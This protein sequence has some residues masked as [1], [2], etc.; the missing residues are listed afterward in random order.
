MRRKCG[1]RPSPGPFLSPRSAPSLLTV[2]LA[3][4]LWEQVSLE[5]DHNSLF[6]TFIETLAASQAAHVI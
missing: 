4:S 6:L 3:S 5:N 1:F 2:R